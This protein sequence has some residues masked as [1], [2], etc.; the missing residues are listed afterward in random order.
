MSKI[1]LSDGFY[2]LWLRLE[3]ALKLAV[4]FLSHPGED[5]LVGIPLTN[6]M[7]WCLLPPNF[8]A[9][10]ETVADFANVS[11]ENPF[12][13]ATARMNPHRL[14]TISKTAPMDIPPIA[15]AHIP[16][17][18]CT[19]PF[20][21]PLRYWDIYVDN[22]CGLVQGNRWTRQWVKR[23]LLCSLDRVFRPLDNNDTAF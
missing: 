14:H 21:K 5:P 12:E 20:K 13:Q 15:L 2:H 8:S 3:D 22:F 18:L 19:A 17:I 23:I 4:L 7:G 16:S 6:S 9:C 1:D 11:L 10:T